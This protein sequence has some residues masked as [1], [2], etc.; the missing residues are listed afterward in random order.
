[1][2]G[3]QFSL[4]DSLDGDEVDTSLTDLDQSWL[5]GLSIESTRTNSSFEKYSITATQLVCVLQLHVFF[6]IQCHLLNFKFTIT[7]LLDF[8]L[9]R[10]MNSMRRKKGL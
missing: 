10:R 8:L 1:M 6:E 7:A 3:G 9:S 4:N 2:V 5:S